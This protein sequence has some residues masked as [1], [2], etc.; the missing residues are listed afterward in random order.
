MFW[1]GVKLLGKQPLFQG[2]FSALLGQYHR[3]L[4][5]RSGIAPLWGHDPSGLSTECWSVMSHCPGWSGLR[6]LSVFSAVQV[7]S[8]QIPGH[9]P[10]SVEFHPVNAHLNTC[11]LKSFLK[12]FLCP[13]FFSLEF[14]LHEVHLS[15]HTQT[16]VSVSKV[17]QDCPP[18]WDSPLSTVCIVPLVKN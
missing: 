9:F 8:L 6:C 4:Y 3:S 14:C 16:Q 5:S 12:L 1:Q 15:Q 10:G 7:F 11:A 17:Q 18:A 2:L 13:V